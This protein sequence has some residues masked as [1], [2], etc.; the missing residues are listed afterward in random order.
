MA[1]RIRHIATRF[2]LLLAIAAVAPLVAY[3]IAS[4]LSLRRGTHDSV[5]NGNV[6]VATR[7]AKEFRWR[8]QGTGDREPPL[9]NMRNRS[10]NS[11]APVGSRPPAAVCA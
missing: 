2:A 3:G 6:N 7:A 11:A 4:I 9:K 5:V 10:V 1:F 8:K